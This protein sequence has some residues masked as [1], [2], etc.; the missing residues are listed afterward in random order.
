M[1]VPKYNYR[2]KFTPSDEPCS[3]SNFD[4]RKSSCFPSNSFIRSKE[5]GLSQNSISVEGQLGL[6]ITS[7]S[8]PV[9]YIDSSYDISAYFGSTV[10]VKGVSSTLTYTVSSIIYNGGTSQL[11]VTVTTAISSSLPATMYVPGMILSNYDLQVPSKARMLIKRWNYEL[12]DVVSSEEYIANLAITYDG[13]DYSG[14][15]GWPSLRIA[16]NAGSNL[17]EMPNRGV[18]TVRDSSY[19][20]PEGPF[21]GFDQLFMSDAEGEPRHPDE[22]VPPIRTGPYKTIINVNIE[23]SID[24]TMTGATS[25]L[26][27]FN[28]DR[29][30]IF[31]T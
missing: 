13:M 7:V 28:G 15:F 10:I 30:I 12:K 23:T 17:I 3:L 20:A 25:S 26:K 9:F 19:T 1:S 5:T 24:G 22:A 27:E 16:V 11:E 8:S 18:D 2:P 14:T 6:T 21:R 31:T 4:S 29:W